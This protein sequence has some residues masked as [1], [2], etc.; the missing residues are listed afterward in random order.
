MLFV[1]IERFRNGDPKPVYARFAERGRMA[2]D[3]VQY[4]NSWTTN[5]L[6]TCYQVMACESRDLLDVWI[7]RWSDLVDFEVHEVMTSGD[8]ARAVNP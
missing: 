7:A 4:I 8:A 6:R 3:G 2:P 5:D 1:V